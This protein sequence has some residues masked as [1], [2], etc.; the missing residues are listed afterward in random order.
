[1]GTTRRDSRS[2]T[3]AAGV[4]LALAG[5]AGMSLAASATIGFTAPSAETW[6][7]FSWIAG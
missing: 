4:A 7:T 1:M 2:T 6:F 3:V 5:L